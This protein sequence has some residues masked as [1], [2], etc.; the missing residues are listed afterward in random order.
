MSLREVRVRAAPEL[1]FVLGA[2]IV[3]VVLPHLC[4]LLCLLALLLASI[5]RSLT[6]REASA[7]RR[8]EPTWMAHPDVATGVPTV[9]RGGVGGAVHKYN[10]NELVRNS[11]PGPWRGERAVVRASAGLPPRGLY[12]AEH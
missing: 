2:P 3:L 9:K 5:D 12:G 4:A 6:H 10:Q 1:V 7:R 8:F 11:V